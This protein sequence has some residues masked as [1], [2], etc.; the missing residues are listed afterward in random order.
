MSVE[1][2]KITVTQTAMTSHLI[3][4]QRLGQIVLLLC[5]LVIVGN[6]FTT[7]RRVQKKLFVGTSV[8]LLLV[9]AIFVVVMCAAMHYSSPNRHVVTG[10]M[11]KYLC[12]STNCTC[13]DDPP[14]GYHPVCSTSPFGKMYLPNL[15]GTTTME[16]MLNSSHCKL[17]LGN[18]A[19]DSE[20]VSSDC[21][22]I[23]PT[24]VLTPVPGTKTESHWPTWAI[25][26]VLAASLVVA[27]YVDCYLSQKRMK[28]KGL[29][30]I[31]SFGDPNDMPEIAGHSSRISPTEGTS[32]D[33]G[34]VGNE[35]AAMNRRERPASTANGSLLSVRHLSYDV[36][37]EGRK[38]QVLRD[39]SF[40][41]ASGEVLALMGPSGAGKTTLLD[42][43]ACR[44]KT[45]HLDGVVDLDGVNVATEAAA[46]KSLVGYVA[47]EDT[48]IPS[49]T[50]TETITFAARFKLPAVFSAAT[51]ASIVS[52]VITTLGL[53]HCK[54]TIVGS[55]TNRGLSGGEK[56]RVSIA[57]ELVSRPRILFLDEP[58]SGLD[59]NSAVHVMEAISATARQ[60]GPLQSTCS[61]FNYTP[62]VVFSIHQPSI[63]VF[64]LFDRVLLLARGG[65][66]YRGDAASAVSNVIR[67]S[68]YTGTPTTANPAD[69]LLRFEERLSDA[70]RSRLL[71]ATEPAP[72]VVDEPSSARVESFRME[73]WQQF[74][75][76]ACRSWR[77][78]LGSYYLLSSH[79]AVT[80]AVGLFMS[81]L[82]RSEPLDLS[83]ALNRAGSLSFL[84]LVLAFVCIS[85]LELFLLE[86]K[87]FAVER[88]GA[89]YSTTP[90]YICK[91]LFDL[92]PLRMVPTLILG[93]IIYFAMGYRVDDATFFMW[94]LFVLVIFV[95]AITCLIVCVGIVLPSFGPS[96]LVSSILIL[97]HFVFGGLLVQ[98]DTIPSALK[99]FRLTSPFFLAFETLMINELDGRPCT[100]APRDAEGKTT[101]TEIPLL[102]VQYL[103]NL[104]LH[105]DNFT[106]DI[107]LLVMWALVYGT[108]GW[109]LL[110]RFGKLRK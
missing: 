103:F 65:L 67:A 108:L 85:C 31:Q 7:Q 84:L 33:E 40:Q 97:W 76:L 73:R 25:P 77:T 14:Q 82:Y 16:C 100:F 59:S 17:T 41:V 10:K 51:V 42:I 90:Y 28:A 55:E 29:A 81:L 5:C 20:C 72:E 102:C 66:L 18:F 80:F 39:V 12:L 45:G 94:F 22:E 63:E 79:A 99:P 70:E 15:K 52:S 32:D 9:L 53:T 48:L 98:A 107:F 68:G 86:R 83:G 3:G 49:L 92:I 106:R 58:T 64:Q 50:V 11:A 38:K 96:A 75:V 46:F 36:N 62:I 74:S 71:S 34:E 95:V 35:R 89:F 91:L 24:A 104:G 57:V 101:S 21:A 2:E 44:E 54:D 6:G 69:F 1:E 23:S 56:R 13:A 26:T 109:I 110:Y 87:L 47:Q 19:I 37:V 27:A 105:P 43:L 61:F 93:S 4:L 8:F 78:L 30:F 60:R 88:D